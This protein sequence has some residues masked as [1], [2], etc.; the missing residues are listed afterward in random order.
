MILPTTPHS[1]AGPINS[2][3]PQHKFWDH[4]TL[5][6]CCGLMRRGQPL[7]ISLQGGN[8]HSTPAL[9][10]PDSAT[11][12]CLPHSSSA[13]WSPDTIGCPGDPARIPRQSSTEFTVQKLVL[14]GVSYATCIRYQLTLWHPDLGDIYA[15]WLLEF[16][17]KPKMGNFPE[18]PQAGCNMQPIA[19]K[20]PN[21][22]Y[23][24]L[25][26]GG[27]ISQTQ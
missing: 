4:C 3:V 20:C 6:G 11:E 10:C 5:V 19:T 18:V 2:L 1:Q 15:P 7:F 17:R 12:H 25:H 21:H 16:N 22:F 8:S 24:V 27:R 13:T 14:H 26:N 9:V 23:S